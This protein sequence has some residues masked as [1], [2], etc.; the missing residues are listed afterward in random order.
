V[1][2]QTRANWQRIKDHL[3]AVGRTDN[4]YYRRALAILAGSPDPLDR[5]NK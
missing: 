4:W 1:D 2:Q 3:E 5:L